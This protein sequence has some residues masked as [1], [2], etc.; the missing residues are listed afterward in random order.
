M[1]KYIVHG[2]HVI[3]KNDKEFHY[4]SEEDVIRLYNVPRNLCILAKEAKG[5]RGT[6]N[7]IHLYPSQDGNYELPVDIP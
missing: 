4:L 2:G 1:I 7:Y 3:S 6:D 5:L